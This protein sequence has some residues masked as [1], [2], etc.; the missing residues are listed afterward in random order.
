VFVEQAVDLAPRL[1]LRDMAAL[2]KPRL[3]MLVLCT[4]GVGLWLAPGSLPLGRSLLTLLASALVVGAANGLNC[5]LERDSDALMRRTRTRPLPARRMDPHT[6]LV[7]SGVLGVVSMAAL[8]WAANPLTAL[9]SF[10]AFAVYVWVYTPMKRYSWLAVLVGAVPGAIPPLM[11][12][13]AVTGALE[14][15]GWALF[16][17]L[18]FWQLPHFFAIAVYLKDDYARGGLKVL[19]VVW[20][21]RPTVWWT[22]AASVALVPVTLTPVFLGF[23]GWG[24]GAAALVLGISFVMGTLT[25]LWSDHV[26][27]WARQVFLASIGYLTL[28][29]ASLLM[30]A[31]P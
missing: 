28:L 23:A 29:M 11:G 1:A 30:G 25:G 3:S 2:A 16:A 13:T 9:L 15:P 26:G 17:I 7:L 31:H 21:V 27:R 8:Y 10:V 19:P 24:Y 4:T 5:Y 20:G 18:F 22:L 12:Y 6:A 14:A